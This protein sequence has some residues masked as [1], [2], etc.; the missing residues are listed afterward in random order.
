MAPNP[1]MEESHGGPSGPRTALAGLYASSLHLHLSC[2]HYWARPRR[3]HRRCVRRSALLVTVCGSRRATTYNGSSIAVI[4][5]A[6]SVS[7]RGCISFP[8]RC[9]P[10]AS[11]PGSISVPVP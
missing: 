8:G 7:R 11:S 9:G 5:G 10:E 4:D 1:A 6:H 3:P 2:S